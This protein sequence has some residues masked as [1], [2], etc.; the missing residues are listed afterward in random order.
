M[1]FFMVLG[2]SV[3]GER[4]LSDHLMQ[5]LHNNVWPMQE[6]LRNTLRCKGE[7]R[8]FLCFCRSSLVTGFRML[9]A[10]DTSEKKI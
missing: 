9:G 1:V 3:Q 2:G 6:M 7:G 4:A 10:E 5:K 8:L